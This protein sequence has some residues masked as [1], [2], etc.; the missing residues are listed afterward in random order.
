[1]AEI[2]KKGVFRILF[3]KKVFLQD[4][5]KKKG[6][7]RIRNCDTNIAKMNYVEVFIFMFPMFYK[8]IGGQFSDL[9][10]DALDGLLAILATLLMT[11]SFF[12]PFPLL[13]I[14]TIFKKTKAD[15]TVRE[16]EKRIQKLNKNAKT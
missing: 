12:C 10:R 15:K 6:K 7:Y 14:Q 1:M 2:Y 5:D 4:Y 8:N 13:I 9:L 16:Q 11:I 3:H